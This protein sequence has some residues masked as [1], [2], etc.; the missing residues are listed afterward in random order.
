MDTI[1][2]HSNI[3]SGL[4]G[5]KTISYPYY[6]DLALRKKGNP[7]SELLCAI[8]DYFKNENISLDQKRNGFVAL[9]VDAQSEFLEGMWDQWYIKQIARSRLSLRQFLLNHSELFE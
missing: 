6:N 3:H 9:K 7:E 1:S 8:K 2:S 5:L 4:S